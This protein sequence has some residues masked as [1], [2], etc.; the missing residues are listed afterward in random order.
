MPVSPDSFVFPKKGQSW[1]FTLY[2]DLLRKEAFA[3][4]DDRYVL[5]IPLNI[6][7]HFLN[8]RRRQLID[9]GLNPNTTPV[10]INVD[11]LAHEII[12]KIGLASLKIPHHIEIEELIADFWQILTWEGI[13]SKVEEGLFLLCSAAVDNWEYQVRPLAAPLIS[14]YLQEARARQINEVMLPIVEC[15]DRM[16]G[17]LVIKIGLAVGM[18]PEHCT[19]FYTYLQSHI[20]KFPTLDEDEF[21]Q[22]C[23]TRA[24]PL[25]QLG[26][27]YGYILETCLKRKAQKPSPKIT[28]KI[29]KKLEMNDVTKEAS[30]ILADITKLKVIRLRRILRLKSDLP[31]RMERQ[32]LRIELLTVYDKPIY[33]EDIPLLNLRWEELPPTADLSE[34]IGSNISSMKLRVSTPEPLSKLNVHVIIEI[35]A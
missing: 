1:E 9:M 22:F 17:N 13:I 11:A 28:I 29:E 31:S 27:G 25:L 34:T 21:M 26:E 15:R 32:L 23:T 10:N 2:L 16:L 30:I 35:S 3:S 24:A 19:A 20:N 18:M 6:L 12:Q 14:K 5:F 7:C 4:L 8:R 33:S